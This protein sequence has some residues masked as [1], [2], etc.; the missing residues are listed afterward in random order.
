MQ[1]IGKNCHKNQTLI[2]KYTFS[3]V[4]FIIPIIFDYNPIIISIPKSLAAAKENLASV[5]V[6]P[7]AEET[8]TGYSANDESRR[9]HPGRWSLTRPSKD[10]QSGSPDMK[11]SAVWPSRRRGPRPAKRVDR[12][13]YRT[14]SELGREGGGDTKNSKQP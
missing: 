4:H 8:N 6:A 1:K 13:R 11:P 14:S 7:T 2:D 9:N 10:P 12:S 5:N 3:M